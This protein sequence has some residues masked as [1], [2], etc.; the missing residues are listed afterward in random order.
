MLNILQIPEDFQKKYAYD[1][2]VKEYGEKEAVIIYAACQIM[3]AGNI[4]G[5]PYSAFQSRRKG[6]AYKDSSLFFELGMLIGGILILPIA[7]LN[8][9]LRGLIGLSNQRLDKSIEE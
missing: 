9:V 4:Y 3:I 6:E 2:I 1:A 5:I 8:G 7:L